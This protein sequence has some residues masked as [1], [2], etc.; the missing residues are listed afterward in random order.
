MIKFLQTIVTVAGFIVPLAMFFE[1]E[2]G[3]GEE[4]KTQVLVAL[5]GELDR[6][7]LKLPAWAER[8]V[9]PILSLLIDA[10]VNYLNRQGFFEHGG[11][12]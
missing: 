5:L 2:G 12:S 1:A 9:E 8:F 11:K 7:G 4:K 6:V 3:T 10:V